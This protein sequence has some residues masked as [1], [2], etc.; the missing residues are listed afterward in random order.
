MQKMRLFAVKY[1]LPMLIGYRF[2]HQYP[3]LR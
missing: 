2:N 3:A 1:S